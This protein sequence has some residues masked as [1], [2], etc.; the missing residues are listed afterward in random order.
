MNVKGQGTL[1][2]FQHSAPKHLKGSEG[3]P[4]QSPL[5]KK[6]PAIQPGKLPSRHKLPQTL[7]K[8]GIASGVKCVWHNTITGKALEKIKAVIGH[9][10]KSKS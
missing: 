8:S 4:L 2:Y 3:V 5:G 6:A 1:K 9:L 7:R 10:L